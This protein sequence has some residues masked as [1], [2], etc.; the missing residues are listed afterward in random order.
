[1]RAR[2]LGLAAAAACLAMPVY[3]AVVLG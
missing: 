1:M 2:I 3:A